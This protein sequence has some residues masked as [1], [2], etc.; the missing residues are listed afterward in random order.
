[1]CQNDWSIRPKPRN[2]IPAADT[3][4]LQHLFSLTI[5]KLHKKPLTTL[6]T[7]LLTHV[8]ALSNEATEKNRA[9]GD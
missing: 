2:G 1:M 6:K 9:T 7:N 3:Q 5:L 8:A 4:R